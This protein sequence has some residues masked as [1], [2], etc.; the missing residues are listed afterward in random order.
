MFR[1]FCI[2]IR[3]KNGLSDKLLEAL[4][5]KVK[6]YS[7]GFICTEK[8]DEERHAH[9]QIW[10]DKKTTK[11]VISTDF[12]RTQSKLDPDWSEDAN[13]VFR[14]GIDIAYSDWYLDYC[15]M[16]GDKI[17][18]EA[19]NIVFENIPSN[20]LEYYPSEDDQK[21][22]LAKSKSANKQYFSLKEK[23]I[24]DGWELQYKGDMHT[25]GTFIYTEM[26]KNDTI[27]IIKD[28]K[29][30]RW[31]VNCLLKYIEQDTVPL[32]IF[33]KNETELHFEQMKLNKNTKGDL[34]II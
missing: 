13:R 1:S 25:V 6:K 18:T 7:F 30:R 28:P 31:L 14:K 34:F 33:S 26:F 12:Q 4:I 32:D 2:T 20:T 24:N 5:K 22:A 27:P 29:Q 16:N 23:F 21:K 10:L 8:E 9:I 15:I 11:G 19:S 3:P 17:D